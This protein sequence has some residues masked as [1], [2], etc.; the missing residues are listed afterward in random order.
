ME[1]TNEPGPT[2]VRFRWIV[3]MSTG[4]EMAQVGTGGKGEGAVGRRSSAPHVQGKYEGEEWGERAE[5]TA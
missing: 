2:S 3:S 4:P 5:M 1:C